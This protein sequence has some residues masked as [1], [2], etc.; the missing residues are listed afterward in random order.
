VT[1]F[2]KT[3]LAC[4][5]GCST[6]QLNRILDRLRIARWYQREFT[7]REVRAVMAQYYFRRGKGIADGVPEPRDKA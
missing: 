1:T 5:L 7:E 2:S 4:F 6:A 3:T